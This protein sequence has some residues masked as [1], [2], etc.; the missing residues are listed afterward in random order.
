MGN[1]V[2]S[3]QKDSL[4]L[5]AHR[6]TPEPES[7]FM[8]QILENGA[9]IDMVEYDKENPSL[10]KG[11]SPENGEIKDTIKI[12]TDDPRY[13]GTIKYRVVTGDEYS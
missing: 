1:D 8:F 2:V 11:G 10:A 9:W 13:S 12:S 7:Y 5:V 3:C 6:R 4:S